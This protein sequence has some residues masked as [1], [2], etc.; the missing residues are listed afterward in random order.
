MK[1]RDVVRARGHTF[2]R[3]THKT[4]FE[5]TKEHA[6]TASGDCIIGVA[7]DK[8]A[9]DLHPDLKRILRHDRAVLITRLSVADETVEVRSKGSAAFTL[10]HPTDLVWR[11]SGFISDRTVGIH[12]DYVA[13]TLPRS[14]ISLLEK[15]EDLVIEL[16][17]EVPEISG[18]Q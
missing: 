11:R 10:D 14:F 6:L 1:A 8:G 5:V 18:M 17:A 3:G 7:A 9:A 13:A 16:I 15:G 2:V 4:T 12:S